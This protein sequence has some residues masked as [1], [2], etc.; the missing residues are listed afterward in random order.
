M[1]ARCVCLLPLPSPFVLIDTAMPSTYNARTD[2][3]APTPGGSCAIPT[4]ASA[5]SSQTVPNEKQ[6]TDSLGSPPTTRSAVR[7][8]V[9]ECST[10]ATWTVSTPPLAIV[11]LMR[12]GACLLCA[13]LG[14]RRVCAGP[15]QVV[16][17]G[18][19]GVGHRDSRG[20]CGLVLAFFCLW[21]TARVPVQRFERGPCQWIASRFCGGMC[22]LPCFGTS[23]RGGGLRAVSDSPT[24]RREKRGG[25][26]GVLGTGR[27]RSSGAC[28]HWLGKPTEYVFSED[29][30]VRCGF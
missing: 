7:R 6:W 18:E 3:G 24:Y 29:W 26:F 22:G 13:A 16:V 17:V 10:C 11:R 28:A 1:R 5:A 21:A 9:L 15:G 25:T 27:A 4:R 19:D 8:R 20:R 14:T 12:T 30:G 23:A 2:V